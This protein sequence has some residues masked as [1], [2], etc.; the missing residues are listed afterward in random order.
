MKITDRFRAAERRRGDDAG[1]RGVPG[2]GR[3]VPARGVRSQL[4][5]LG[6]GQGGTRAENVGGRQWRDE[7]FGLPEQTGDRQPAHATQ[8][9]HV[10]H[11]GR[12]GS[13]PAAAA[14]SM[15]ISC[16]PA[17]EDLATDVFATRWYTRRSR[18][19]WLGSGTGVALIDVEKHVAYWCTGAA[20]D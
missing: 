12:E 13:H 19:G 5:G 10:L 7:P 14:A 8:C 15:R 9:P 18:R 11:Q 3:P 20:E 4:E 6:A 16:G 2:G 17:S 1:G